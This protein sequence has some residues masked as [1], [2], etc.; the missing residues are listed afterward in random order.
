MLEL[1]SKII[2]DLREIQFFS[3]FQCNIFMRLRIMS[4]LFIG[5]QAFCEDISDLHMLT[6]H[7]RIYRE[8][9]IDIMRK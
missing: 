5:K 4:V 2:H 1:R 7:E 8:S 6:I 9:D 3:C